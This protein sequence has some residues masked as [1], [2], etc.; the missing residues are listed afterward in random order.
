MQAKESL[1]GVHKVSSGLPVDRTLDRTP[2]VA[3]AW[4]WCSG[5]SGTVAAVVDT[6]RL[7]HRADCSPNRQNCTSSVVAY[8]GDD[9]N[10]KGTQRNDNSKQTMLST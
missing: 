6:L 2:T 7:L 5:Q 8:R 9:Q 3:E 1:Y 4:W 10:R